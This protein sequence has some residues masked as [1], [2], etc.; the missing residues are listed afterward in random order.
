MSSAIISFPHLVVRFT[1]SCS[2]LA[3]TNHKKTV[4][5][6]RRGAD[7]HQYR[8][9]R[10]L[11]GRRAESAEPM[12]RQMCNCLFAATTPK[13]NF[14]QFYCSRAFVDHRTQQH[15]LK[16]NEAKKKME[17]FFNFL[18]IVSVHFILIHLLASVY[19]FG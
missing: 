9:L 3:S 2:L 12:V 7:R 16:M 5:G 6:T 18:Q 19:G 11:L 14:N 17:N 15:T 10:S 4:N 8:W 1:F 13:A